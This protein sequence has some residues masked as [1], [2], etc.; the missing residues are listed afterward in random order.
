MAD[1]HRCMEAAAKSDGL[2]SR[3][4]DV[5][6]RL[7]RKPAPRRPWSRRYLSAGEYEMIREAGRQGRNLAAA[8]K[9]FQ[10]FDL[11]GI[12]SKGE[13]GERSI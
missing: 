3:R 12:D 10:T 4:L 13:L 6:H 11:P 7:L 2:E 8:Q 5:L 9:L 1:W